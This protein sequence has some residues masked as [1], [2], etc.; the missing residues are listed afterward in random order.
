V[1]RREVDERNA[2]LL[3]QALSSTTRSTRAPPFT[4]R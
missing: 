1:V 2:H 3:V 4:R